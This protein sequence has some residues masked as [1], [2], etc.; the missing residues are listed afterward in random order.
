[1]CY[2]L[3]CHTLTP[4]LS[5]LSLTVPSLETFPITQHHSCPPWFYSFCPVLFLHH[6]AHPAGVRCSLGWAS[7]SRVIGSGLREVKQPQPS[8]GADQ[9][10]SLGGGSDLGVPLM[11]FSAHPSSSLPC[12][13]QWKEQKEPGNRRVPKVN[14][15]SSCL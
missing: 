7:V 13:L 6:S 9:R 5:S 14:G 11:A 12:L 2:S 3:R 10:E 8:P 4:I 15:Q 1:M